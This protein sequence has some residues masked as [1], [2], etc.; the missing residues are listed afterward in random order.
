MNRIC[1]WL[2]ACDE[3]V[4]IIEVAKDLDGLHPVSLTRAWLWGEIT[5]LPAVLSL[6][7]LDAA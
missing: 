1:S 2:N 3:A 6:A 4:E 7:M 5:A